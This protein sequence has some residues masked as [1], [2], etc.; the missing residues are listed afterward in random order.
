[1]TAIKE[2]SVANRYHQPRT[3]L[4]IFYYELESP[5]M[6][7]NG[8][9]EIELLD[10]K[11]SAAFLKISDSSLRRLQQGRKIPFYKI[12]GLIR[13]SKRDIVDYLMKQRVA[14]LF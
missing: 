5:H 12:G 14:A 3:R 9:V 13:F 7:K 10:L 1:M 4:A 6:A 11:E 8:E 2:D